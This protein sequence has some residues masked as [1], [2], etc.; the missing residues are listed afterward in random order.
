MEDQDEDEEEERIVAKTPLLCV[1]SHVCV[2][3]GTS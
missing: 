1:S 2:Y 3:L